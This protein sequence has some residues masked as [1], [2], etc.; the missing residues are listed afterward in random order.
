MV[1]PPLCPL[2]LKVTLSNSCGTLT[3]VFSVILTF[4][5]RCC[6]GCMANSLFSFPSNV[7]K[8]RTNQ[9]V[10]SLFLKVQLLTFSEKM[11]KWR[12][13]RH[14]LDH[15]IAFQNKGID[16]VIRREKMV[17]T[18]MPTSPKQFFHIL[19]TALEPLE[20][21]ELKPIRDNFIHFSEFQF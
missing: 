2:R 13:S 17:T 3:T 9:R 4:E 14:D 21:F 11:L 15:L 12:L 19:Q 18:T 10:N 7:E 16:S 20:P 5:R 6:G 8:K 1:S